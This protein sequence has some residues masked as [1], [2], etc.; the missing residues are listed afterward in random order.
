M[1]VAVLAGSFAWL[2]DF[3]AHRAEFIK[4]PLRQLVAHPLERRHAV[5]GGQFLVD[6]SRQLFTGTDSRRLFLGKIAGFG[7]AG[8]RDGFAEFVRAGDPDFAGRIFLQVENERAAVV[9]TAAARVPVTVGHGT[10]AA[11]ILRQAQERGVNG[12]FFRGDQ[13]HLDFAVAE[14]EHL[15]PEHRGVGDAHQLEL[16]LPGQSCGR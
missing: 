14:G 5:A 10:D 15:G 1:A 2:G 9:M 8:Q 6:D 16:A 13:A 12:L 7:S 3:A 11:V 4:R